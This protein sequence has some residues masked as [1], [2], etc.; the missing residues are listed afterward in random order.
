MPVAASDAASLHVTFS[1]SAKVSLAQALDRLG[2]KDEILP[3]VDHLGAGPIDPGTFEE[4][5]QWMDEELG[6]EWDEWEAE[7]VPAFWERVATTRVPILA[8]MSSRDADEL[9]GFHELLWRVKEAPVSVVDAAAMELSFSMIRSDAM[10]DRKLYE[11]VARVTDD[12][13]ARHAAVWQRLRAENAAPRVVTSEGLVSAPVT[14][15]DETIASFVT[16][17]WQ[18]CIKVVGAALAELWA[19]GHRPPGGDNFVFSRLLALM[20]DETI[21]GVSD[22]EYWSAQ[23]SRVRRVPAR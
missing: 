17:D 10:I 23:K 2:R 22:E 15:F 5:R 6:I 4:R 11:R 14:Y 9:C 16:G 1:A 21:E 3:L 20:D 8:W 12:E 7:H 19:H 13:R 18:K